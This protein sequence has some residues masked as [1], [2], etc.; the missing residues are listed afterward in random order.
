MT[1]DVRRSNRL[2]A[3]KSPYLQQHS[4]NPVDWYPWGEEAFEEAHRQNKPVFLSIGYST[5]H[6]CHVMAHESFEDSEVAERLNQVFISVKVDREER[7]D[8]DKVYMQVA[9]MMTGRGGWPLTL[10]LTPDKEPFFAGTYLPKHSQGGMLGLIELTERVRELWQSDRDNIQEVV[11]RVKD[12]LAAQQRHDALPSEPDIE[13]LNAAFD[14]YVA[15]FDDKHGGFG[16]APKFPSPH[17]LM[18]LLRHWKRT[19][20]D[21]ALYMVDKTLREMRR[22]GVYDHLGGGFHRY[23]TDA[24]W[25]VP[26]FEK[27][28]YDQAMMALACLEA[29]QATGTP[30][31]ASVVRETLDFVLRELQDREGG[32]LS[33]IDADSEGQEGKF[34]VWSADEIR[35][36]LSDD[37]YRV[38][39][40]AFNVR[41]SGNFEDEASGSPTGLN[42]LYQ[43]YS[44]EVNAKLV[45]LPVDQFTQLLTSAKKKLFEMRSRRT[46]PHVD[47][48]VLTDWNGLMIA[49][50]A[51]AGAILNEREYVQSAERAADFIIT[52]MSNGDRLLHRY[53]DGECAVEAF[54]DDYAFLILGLIELYQSTFEVKYLEQA[55]RLSKLTVSLFWDSEGGGFFFSPASSE[56]MLTRPKD[57]YDGAIPSGNSMMVLNSIRLGRLLGDESMEQTARN[58]LNAFA[59]EIANMPMSH[60][61]MLVA[62]DYLRGPSHEVIVAGAPDDVVTVRM[63]AEIRR[64]YLPSVMLI[65]VGT[66]QQRDSITRLAPYVRFYGPING[67]TTAYVCIDRTC[68]LPTDDVTQMLHQL[69]VHHL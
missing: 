66:E 47:D 8:I 34:Y 39:V 19:G 46:A 45:G 15:R 63:I 21:F 65:L 60:S 41:E 9:Q 36:S 38:I 23:A 69:G 54:L 42:I 51:R 59:D 50:M 29:Y 67:R 12:A 31:F 1:R 20:N 28:L 55:T 14:G 61:M 68:Q 49:A 2:A 6:W 62:I 44:D 11:T 53:R 3:E 7:P 40:T 24:L 33:A 58:T 26:H 16:T 57:A 37:E 32:F 30:L 10:V 27:M 52:R 43:T 4:N 5:C 35:A 18:L 25:R 22:G 13:V 56:S 17:N 64:R 48:K